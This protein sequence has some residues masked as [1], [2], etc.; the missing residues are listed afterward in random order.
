MRQAFGFLTLSPLADDRVRLR[1]GLWGEAEIRQW[2]ITDA[3]YAVVVPESLDDYRITCPPCMR[4]AESLLARH[5]RQVAVLT[6]YPGL[7]HIVYK[8]T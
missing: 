5:F 7:A 4:V 1:S 2:L 8:R 6:Q 3:D